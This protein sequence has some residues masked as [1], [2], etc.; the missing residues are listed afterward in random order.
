MASILYACN[1]KS[2]SHE[3]TYRPAQA[4]T[5]GEPVVGEKPD[6]PITGPVLFEQKC[7]SCHGND[8]TAGIANA[9]NLQNSRLKKSAV[10]EMI[11]NGKGGMPPFKG[12]LS[13]E[14]LTALSAY[15]LTL[16]K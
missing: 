4:V 14:E 2:P 15:V 11:K 6:T 3:E 5:E 13:E 9:A 1:S 10:M 7:A 12:Q 8:G 16:R